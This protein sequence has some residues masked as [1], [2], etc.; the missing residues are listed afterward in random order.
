[1]LP[2]QYLQKFAAAV[3]KRS[4]ICQ[5]TVEAVLPAVFDEI[6]H[7]LIEGP[8]PC[9]PIESFG[10]FA[11]IEKPAREYHYYRPSKGIDEWRQLPP[12]KMVKF[13]PTRNMRRELE[14]GQLDPTRKSF[15]RNPKDPPIKTRKNMKY[16][17]PREIAVFGKY[18]T[19]P[20]KNEP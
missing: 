20:G 2:K 14:R 4:G 6:R 19:L 16:C 8:W 13:S 12:K 7:Q 3:T 5:A 9:V 11:I 15:S 18:S 10:T 1:M 17:K